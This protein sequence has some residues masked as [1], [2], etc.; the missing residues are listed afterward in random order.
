MKTIK[1]RIND[2]QSEIV[3][4]IEKSQFEV[5]SVG[6]STVVNLIGE[7]T[8]NIDGAIFNFGVPSTKKYIVQ[9]SEPP[10]RLKFTEAAI[11]VLYELCAEKK[12]ALLKEQIAHLEQEIKGL[13]NGNV[14]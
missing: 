14:R 10:V 6:K 2:L 13:E 4:R 3:A 8:I 11:N 7:V 12:R 5:I 1:N 9:F